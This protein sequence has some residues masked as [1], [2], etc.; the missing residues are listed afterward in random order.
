MSAAPALL[1]QRVGMAV[2][3]RSGNVD[4]TSPSFAVHRASRSRP[5][6]VRLSSTATGCPDASFYRTRT[7]SSPTST[8]AKTTDENLYFL[9]DNDKNEHLVE[10]VDG[11]PSGERSNA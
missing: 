10:S 1:P 4:D 8:V 9:T 3:N 2:E 6:A 5:P 7:L 11:H